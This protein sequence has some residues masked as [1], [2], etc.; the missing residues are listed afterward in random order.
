MIFNDLDEAKKLPLGHY[1]RDLAY[2]AIDKEYYGSRE[3]ERR[4]CKRF[5]RAIRHI[6]AFDTPR[7]ITLLTHL[8]QLLEIRPPKIQL[9]SKDCHPSTIG[10]YVALGRTIHIRFSTADISTLLHEFAHHVAS[11]RRLG[12]GHG[13]GFLQALELVWETWGSLD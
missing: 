8:S 5:S 13:D 3:I 10:H 2:R 11:E 9:S 1:E 4:M 7:A 12:W 6:P